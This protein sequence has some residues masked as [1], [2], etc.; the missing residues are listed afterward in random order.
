MSDLPSGLR[1]EIPPRLKPFLAQW[2]YVVE[3][4]FD[5]MAG[6]TDAE[7]LWEP[8]DEVWT[9]RLVDGRPRPDVE[10]WPADAS[11][12]PPRTL[13]WTLGHLGDGAATRADWLVGSHSLQDGDLTW[14]MQASDGLAFARRGLDAWRDG[15]A[16]M[17]DADLDTV[18]RSAY[19]GG[20]DPE[21]PLIDI[22]WWVNKELL[23]H[24]G[25]AWFVR[26]LYAARGGTSSGSPSSA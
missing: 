4:L 24:A 15:L 18:G 21:L 1:N 25:E 14:P 11:A 13:A 10:T 17:T 16:Q 23:F 6:L 26:D 2:D 22:V 7:Y 3:T 12:A 20:L 5:R 19:P 8:A 9:V